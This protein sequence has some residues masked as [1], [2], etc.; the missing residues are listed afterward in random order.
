MIGFIL[1]GIGGCFLIAGF[2][3]RL[4]HKHINRVE[5]EN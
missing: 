3:V 4:K 5:M 2:I 1:L